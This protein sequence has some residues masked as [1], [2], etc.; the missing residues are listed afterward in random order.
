MGAEVQAH[1]AAHQRLNGR[2]RA[3]VV[4]QKVAPGAAA[5]HQLLQVE[6]RSFGRHRSRDDAENCIGIGRQT[7]DRK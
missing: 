7:A 5:A 2:V 1:D 3:L 6:A 4:H